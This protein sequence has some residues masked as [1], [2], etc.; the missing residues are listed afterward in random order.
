MTLQ[1][2]HATEQNRDDSNQPLSQMIPPNDVS[3]T[4]AAGES[5]FYILAGFV[6]RAARYNGK[7][8]SSSE[9]THLTDA[10][11]ANWRTAG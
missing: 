7:R 9:T 3:C 2:T 8:E 11:Q 10:R 5:F 6:S 4:R 1:V